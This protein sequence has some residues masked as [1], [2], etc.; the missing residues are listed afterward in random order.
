MQYAYVQIF[1][2]LILPR[3]H[4]KYVTSNMGMVDS[5][6]SVYNCRLQLIPSIGQQNFDM[7]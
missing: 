6:E 2:Y 1:M 4:K 3:V 7:I 5:E